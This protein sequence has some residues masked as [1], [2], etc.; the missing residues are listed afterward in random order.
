MPFYDPSTP[1][2]T[3]IHPQW[4]LSA[5]SVDSSMVAVSCNN[6]VTEIPFP[7]LV[8][9]GRGCEG[10]PARGK[11]EYPIFGISSSSAIQHY[12]FL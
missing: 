7:A 2:E 1:L 11:F 12:T 9:Q 4:L 3:D 5:K 10:T 6:A 8:T